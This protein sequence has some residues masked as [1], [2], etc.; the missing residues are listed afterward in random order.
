MA[1]NTASSNPWQAFVSDVKKVLPGA[2]LQALE[3]L[4]PGW[5]AIAKTPAGR[6]AITKA[7]S[8][9]QAGQNAAGA[10]GSTVSDASK[11]NDF[12]T[13]LTEAATWE[14]V[15]EFG[16]G[17]ILIYLGIRALFPGEVAAITSPVKKAAK[18][19]AFL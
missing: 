18:V 8:E 13:R 2:E 3:Q 7:V 19:G 16:I 9:I 11:V 15:A 10:V 4:I 14:R 1:P 12:L 17:T 6:A 5:Q